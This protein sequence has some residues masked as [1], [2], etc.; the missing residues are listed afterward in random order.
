[1]ISRRT[2]TTWVPVCL[3][4]VA[5]V[6]QP[7]IPQLVFVGIIALSWI[8]MWIGYLDMRR[9]WNEIEEATTLYDRWR[10]QRER[11]R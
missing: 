4:C 7:F 2:A 3:I 6:I 5:V 9:E 10:Q 8:P 11:N 1:M